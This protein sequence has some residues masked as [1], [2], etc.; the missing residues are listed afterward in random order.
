EHC[1]DRQRR[2]RLARSGERH[3]PRAVDEDLDERRDLFVKLLDGQA[4]A[5]R[6]DA[7]VEMTEI[8]ARLVVAM[9]A[10]LPRAAGTPAD[11]RSSRASQHRARRHEHVPGADALALG[12]RSAVAHDSA[13]SWESRGRKRRACATIHAL[14]INITANAHSARTSVR[15]LAAFALRIVIGNG[16]S[17]VATLAYRP[18]RL[19]SA[20]IASP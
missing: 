12:D 19:V 14:F 11:A 6:E 7:P 8:V 3:R 16:L 9:I 1:R 4:I 15:T 10:T 13:A 18:N 2:F 20:S 5:A 17:I